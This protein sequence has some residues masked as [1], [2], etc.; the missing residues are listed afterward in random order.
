MFK[1]SLQIYSLRDEC[2]NNFED[3]LKNVSEAGY[4]GVELYSFFDYSKEQ[5]KELLDKYNLVCTSVH[6]GYDL[7]KNNLD[8]V[9]EFNKYI[10]NNNII[11]PYYEA[12]CANDW[13]CLVEFL[14][15]TSKKL[16]E[17][18]LNLL[19]HNHEF[20]FM[21]IDGRLPIDILLNGLTQDEMNFEVDCYWVKYAGLEPAE[22]LNKY[23]NRIKM[24]HIK[25]MAVSGEEKTMTEVGTGIINYIDIVKF[26][27][28]NNFEWLV[29]EQ[30]D[31]TIEKYKSIKL[32]LDNLKKIAI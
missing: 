31:I 22:F 17:H 7:L 6:T 9:I 5:M 32:S 24:L 2:N 14:K 29:I 8:Y 28:L 23:A 4:D 25:D 3:V 26:A 13:D 10:N 16:K 11:L 19:Y 21:P 20:E 15:E 30:D 18:S 27:K 1:F 12:K